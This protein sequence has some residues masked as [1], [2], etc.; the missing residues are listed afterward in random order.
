MNTKLTSFLL[1]VVI[2]LGLNSAS[3]S[4]KD[5]FYY[6][7]YG[8]IQI[9]DGDS[10]AIV[11]EIPVDGWVRESD[12]SADRKFL[13]VVTKRHLIQKIDL[14]TRQVVNTIDAG[15]G[16]WDRFI[17]G[18]D[19]APDGKTAYVNLLSRTTRKGEAVVAPPMLAQIDLEEGRILRS[20][21]VPWGAASLVSVKNATSIYV[22]GKDITKVDVSGKKMKITGTYPMFE[23][24]WNVLP[25]WDNTMGNGG[26]FMVNYYTPEFMGLLSIDAKSGEITDT[27]LEGAP[28]FAYSVMRSPDKKKVYA[29]MDELTVIDLETRSYEHIIPISGG[30]HYAINVS[31]DGSKVY[32]AGGGASTIIFDSKTLKPIKVLQMETDGMDLRRLTH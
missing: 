4:A 21:E 12:F 11:G 6:L 13:Y 27:P 19:L 26:V 15:G 24:K 32:V 31:S 23:K 28:V 1:I 25:L 22:I 3:A 7:G 9:I 8:L 20:I 16:G 14:E 10:D 30:T 2:S 18:F 17:Y 5:T 29:V